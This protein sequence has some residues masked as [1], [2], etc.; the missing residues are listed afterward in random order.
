M[1]ELVRLHPDDPTAWVLYPV[2]E[3][4]VVRFTEKHCPD[5]KTA[6]LC[7]E[8]RERFVSYPDLAGYWVALDGGRVVAHCIAWVGTVWS[9]IFIHLHQAEC[10][11]G[12]NITE[13]VPMFWQGIEEWRENLNAAYAKQGLTHRVEDEIEFWTFRDPRVWERYWGAIGVET[14]HVRSVIK[15]RSKP[16]PALLRMV[17]S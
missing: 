7:K 8:L 15:M 2:M 6:P 10:D 5:I 17:G 1:I 13:I 11:E 12:H 14:T 16:K 4:R 9:S 3:A